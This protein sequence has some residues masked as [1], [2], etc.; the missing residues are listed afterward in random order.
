MT[1]WQMKVD[2]GRLK[3][4]PVFIWHVAPKPYQFGFASFSDE[5]AAKEYLKWVQSHPDGKRE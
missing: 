4:Q 5:G 3:G 1:E 2:V